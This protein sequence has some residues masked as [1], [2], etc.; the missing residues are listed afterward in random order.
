M[1]IEF[2][3]AGTPRSAG[4]K[5]GFLNPKTKK[6][7]F[8]PAGKYQKSWQESIR[9]AAIEAGYNGTMII[10]GAVE[11][12]IE[13]V[14]RRP[15]GHYKSNGELNKKGRD[16]PYKTSKPDLD[17][18]NRAVADALSGLIWRDDSQVVRMKEVGKSY[19]KQGQPEGAYVIITE[20]P[21]ENNHVN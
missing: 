13:Y 18:L 11:L 12:S 16:T 21:K 2:F 7:I 20:L 1:K 3:I 9:W 10:E 8:A 14:Y 6:Y 4:S 19:G 5:S 15:K 17:K